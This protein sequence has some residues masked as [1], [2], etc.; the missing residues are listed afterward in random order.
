MIDTTTPPMTATEDDPR[1]RVRFR[2]QQIVLS[3]ITVAVTI[4]LWM[5]NELLGLAATFFAKHV[6][7]AIFLTGNRLPPIDP[8]GLM[9]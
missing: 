1:W 3:V 6:L 8:M 7:V 5:I 9:G 2:I 4:W